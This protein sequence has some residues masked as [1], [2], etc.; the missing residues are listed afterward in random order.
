MGENTSLLMTQGGNGNGLA[1]LDVNAL[2]RDVDGIWGLSQE[3]DSEIRNP[4]MRLYRGAL[5]VLGRKNEG[6]N[7]LYVLLT[8]MRERSNDL[9]SKLG[10]LEQVYRERAD[11][12]QRY[13]GGLEQK[14][15][16]SV[17]SL[18][19]IS[20]GKEE[21]SKVLETKTKELEAMN[22]VQEGYYRTKN[23]ALLAWVDQ[24]VLTNYEVGVQTNM[25]TRDDLVQK[26][27]ADMLSANKTHALLNV[28]NDRFEDVMNFFESTIGIRMY[29]IQAGKVTAEA[30]GVITDFG[31][32][33]DNSY[34]QAKQWL[35][36][37]R[38]I[39]SGNLRAIGLTGI[40]GQ[41]NNATL[42]STIVRYV[43]G[44]K[45]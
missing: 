16:G 3:V 43:E 26:T 24:K 4:L 1:I 37:L 34:K 12:T 14:Q 11:T 19:R 17:L 27:V 35:R 32:E 29:E 10:E 28:F 31:K 39:E 15:E 33:V 5:R 7:H 23:V 40:S 45:R 13:F 8:A 41:S 6:D 44:I 30:I 22:R 38:Y 2:E 18:H 20:R 25:H 21:T 36:Q 42:D 9:C